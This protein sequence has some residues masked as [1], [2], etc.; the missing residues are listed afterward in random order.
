MSVCLILDTE[1]LSA[2]CSAVVL[3]VACVPF[4]LEVHTY[5]SEFLSA[6]ICIKFNVEEQIKVYKRHISDSVVK[7]WKK[8]SKDVF[9]LAVKPSPNDVSIRD[10]LIQ[11]NKFI[12]EI[13][14]YHYK[15]SYVWT[16]GNNF[17]FPILKSLYGDAG[18]APA[19]N[20]WRARDVRTA[21]D[22]M[23]GTDDAKYNL[24]FGGEGFIPHNPLHD[25]AMDA[26]RLNELFYINM[27]DGDIPF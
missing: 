23:A 27:N 19:Y 4:R 24:R 14:G 8:Q 22:I 21:I 18:I 13:P 15:E 3:S 6:G 5:F 10:G 20:D 7:W 26:A 17:D 9:D 25:A 11:L 2:E 1:T 16:R 12:S